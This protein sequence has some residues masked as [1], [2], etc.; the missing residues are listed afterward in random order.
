MPLRRE[1][2][3]F[4]A[5]AL[6]VLLVTAAVTIVIS[7]RI[8]RAHALNEAQKSAE[9]LAQL[10][11]APAPAGAESDGPQRYAELDRVVRIRI[12]DGSLNRAVIWNRS[13]GVLYSSDPDLQGR[14]YTPSAGVLAAVDGETLSDFGDASDVDGDDPAETMLEVYTPLQVDGERLAFETY[15]S[16]AG[17]EQRAATLRGHLLPVTVGALV[18]LQVVQIPIATSLARRVSRQDAER[19][20]LSQ[21]QVS[22]SHRERRAIAAEVHD[23]PVQEL[24]GVSYALSALKGHLPPERQPRVDH[25]VST[26]QH[27]VRSLRRLI[28]DIYP[29]DLSG[30]SLGTAIGNLVEPLRAEGIEVLMNAGQLPEMSPDA[31]AVLYRTAKEALAN[32]V[33]H[34]QAGRAWITIQATELRGVP[35]ACLEVA[36]D[37]VGFPAEGIDKRQEGH[38]GLSFLRDRVVDL[39]GTVTLATRDEGGAVLTAVVPLETGA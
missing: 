28:V 11:V 23:G 3:T 21:R 30:S 18:L 27:A 29:P 17:L 12:A 38:V 14:R 24:A 35:A 10:A 7:G 9:R 13:G 4:L 37:G 33:H 20:E 32:V 31:A 39:G 22:A 6:L 15:F 8:A 5:V 36:D 34:S 26:A 2:A 25:L 19:A 1:L 16:E